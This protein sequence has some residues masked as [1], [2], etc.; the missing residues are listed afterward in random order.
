L[1]RLSRQGD[2]RAPTTSFALCIDVIICANPM[3]DPGF[4]IEIEAT[5]VLE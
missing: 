2:T 5:V 1:Y 3:V 4:L